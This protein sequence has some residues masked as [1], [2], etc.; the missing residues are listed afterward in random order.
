[1]KEFTDSFILPCFPLKILKSS[2]TP[3]IKMKIILA[4]L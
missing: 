2:K 1:M 3:M 4:M